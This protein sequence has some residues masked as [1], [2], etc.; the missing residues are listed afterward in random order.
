MMDLHVNSLGSA[1]NMSFSGTKKK[2]PRAPPISLRRTRVKG[3]GY[4][5]HIFTGDYYVNMLPVIAVCPLSPLLHSPTKVKPLPTS[6]Q[7]RDGRCSP[8]TH[9]NS[10]LLKYYWVDNID[11]PLFMCG[12]DRTPRLC[13]SVICRVA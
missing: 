12:S 6:F 7:C 10:N 5:H 13:L 9:Y 11:I 2:P 3:V 4:Q 1:R 8:C